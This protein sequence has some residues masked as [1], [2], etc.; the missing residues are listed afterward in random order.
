VV[1]NG[2]VSRTMVANHSSGLLAT[3][4]IATL[5]G[6]RVEKLN[7]G[8][9][10]ETL[11]SVNGVDVVVGGG[12]PVPAAD[13]RSRAKFVGM[14]SNGTTQ[15]GGFHFVP[16]ARGSNPGTEWPP[17]GI[18]VEFDHAVSCADIGGGAA[19]SLV[20]TVVVELYDETA[21]FGRRVRLSHNCSLPLF[22]FDMS[23]SIIGGA[24]DR[25][26]T[27]D[28]D[29]S[30]SWGQ[31]RHDPFDPSVAYSTLGYDSPDHNDP[32]V[33]TLQTGLFYG[34]LY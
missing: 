28:Q 10:P 31:Q 23:I 3:T 21:S 9:L 13:Q 6:G 29:A 27:C 4:S 14:R 33:H 11:F 1:S 25:D 7:G 22:V 26:I 17:R 16:G 32:T 20:A 30:V 15:A 2:I 8:P 34:I 19:G 5:G 24:R 18:H 12:A